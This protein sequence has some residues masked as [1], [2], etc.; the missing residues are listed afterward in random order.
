MK[1]IKINTI[2]YCESHVNAIARAT[3]ELIINDEVNR[4]GIVQWYD[5]TQGTLSNK[6]TQDEM[7]VG[8]VFKI[9]NN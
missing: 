4:K 9:C 2:T 7:N 1:K 3:V 5:A 8:L 6:N